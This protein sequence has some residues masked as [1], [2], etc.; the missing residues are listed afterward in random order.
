[1]TLVADEKLT[2]SMRQIIKGSPLVREHQCVGVFE[3]LTFN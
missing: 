2:R 3:S 1:M